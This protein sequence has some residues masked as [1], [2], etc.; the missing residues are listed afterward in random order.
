M[1]IKS[2]F[3]NKNKPSRIELSIDELVLTGFKFND[4]DAIRESIVSEF[5]SLLINNEHHNNFEK[6]ISLNRLNVGSFH[7]EPDSGVKEIGINTANSIYNGIRNSSSK[8]FK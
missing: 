1:D 4:R 3:F 6:N 5:T 8:N 7:L 2:N